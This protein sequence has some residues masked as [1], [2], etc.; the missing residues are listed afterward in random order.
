M[1]S[2]SEVREIINLKRDTI[3]DVIRR[4]QLDFELNIKRKNLLA[5]ANTNLEELEMTSTRIA[6]IIV[7]S[8]QESN[9][10]KILD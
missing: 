2:S 3:R 7:W 4:K 9:L 8:R 1:K 5:Q 10:S 6:E